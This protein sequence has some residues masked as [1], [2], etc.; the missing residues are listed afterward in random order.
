MPDL[1]S[2]IVPVYNAAS[3][4]DTCIQSVLQQTYSCFEL[5]LVDDSSQ[6]ESRDICEKISLTDNRI[7]F[8]PQE[9]RGVSVAR[10]IALKAA[11]GN[12]VFFLDS[13]D[14]IHPCLLEALHTILNRTQAS[15]AATEYCFRKT[16]IMHQFE[17]NEITPYL[18]THNFNDYIYLANDIVL[19]LFAQGHTHL[20]YGL[21][22]IIFSRT[23]IASLLFDERLTHGED[24][25]FVY[26]T[27]LLGAD[28]AIL[29][30][31]WYYYRIH[32]KSSSA[33]RTKTSCHS[34]Y[35]CES[36][37]RNNEI[38]HNRI[39]NAL[40]LEQAL[41]THICEWYIMGRRNHDIALCSYLRKI[42]T[43]ESHSDFFHQL[44]LNDRINFFLIFHCLPSY[45]I[46]HEFRTLYFY[47]IKSFPICLIIKS[48]C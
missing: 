2:V 10:N 19:D 5:L 38:K 9:H 25:T 21:G 13:D 11:K 28:V 12:Y 15:M 30:K 47:L 27:L 8:F 23:Q 17:R 34:I 3:Y 41:L 48:T 26:R 18:H 42:A 32:E 44:C 45:W 33:I 39:T 43:R 37:M 4:I 24:T 20:L 6:D 14:V 29:H 16:D 7:R 36:Y 40:K 35:K 22:G 1:I 46:L 31:Q